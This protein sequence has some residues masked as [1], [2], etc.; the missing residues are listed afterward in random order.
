MGDF[1]KIEMGKRYVR[2][3]GEIT[4]PLMRR[5]YDLLNGYP[6]F[7]DE[8]AVS[9]T[10]DGVYYENMESHLD[11]IAEYADYQAEIEERCESITIDPERREDIISEHIL[12]CDERNTIAKVLGH[13]AFEAASKMTESERNQG[14]LD[15]AYLVLIPIVQNAIFQAAKKGK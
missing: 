5:D 2:R 6:F 4:A 10:E 15:L 7:D 3:D 11:L 12:C 9:Y 1:M 14:I 8:R 13:W